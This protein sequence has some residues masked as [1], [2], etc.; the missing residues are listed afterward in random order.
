MEGQEEERQPRIFW[1]VREH[2][3]MR[4]GARERE[5]A[6]MDEYCRV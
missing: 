6:E 4:E 5:W 3:G 2:M 1:G